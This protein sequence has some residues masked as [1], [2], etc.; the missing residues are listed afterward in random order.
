MSKPA[1]GCGVDRVWAGR[2]RSAGPRG[3]SVPAVRPERMVRSDTRSLSPRVHAGREGLLHERESRMPGSDD[4][5]ETNPARL[6]VWLRLPLG[7]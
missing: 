3:C 7:A 1:S 6:R 5:S 4:L 2:D